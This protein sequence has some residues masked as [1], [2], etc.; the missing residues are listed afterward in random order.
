MINRNICKECRIEVYGKEGWN[1]I[2]EAWSDPNYPGRMQL[3]HIICPLIVIQNYLN[4]NANYEINKCQIAFKELSNQITLLLKNNI[5]MNSVEDIIDFRIYE[6][7][8]RGITSAVNS[9]SGLTFSK[10][11]LTNKVPA[12]CPYMEKHNENN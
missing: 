6:K 8:L 7:G 2:A 4:L 3:S 1:D 9:L 5:T 12:W 10:Q 11:F